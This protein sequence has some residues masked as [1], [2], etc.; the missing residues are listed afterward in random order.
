MHVYET[1]VP[2]DTE[3]RLLTAH[4]RESTRMSGSGYVIHMNVDAEQIPMQKGA[5]AG[6]HGA[7]PGEHTYERVGLCRKYAC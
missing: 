5:V 1:Q 3:W 6:D 4:W 2:T 7:L